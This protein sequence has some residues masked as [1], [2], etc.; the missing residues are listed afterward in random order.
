MLLLADVDPLR[1]NEAASKAIMDIKPVTKSVHVEHGHVLTNEHGDGIEHFGYADGVSQPLF[2]KEDVDKGNES[3]QENKS[4]WDPSAGLNLVLSYDGNGTGAY[5]YGSYFVFRKLEQNVKGFK[6]KEEE[7]ADALHLEGHDAERAGALL[8]GRFEDGTPITLQGA[9]GMRH[10]IPNGFTF[11]DDG[12]GLRCPFQAHIR[13]VNP[14]TE[15]KNGHRI[16]RRGIP[17]GNRQPDLGDQPTKDVGLLFMCYQQRIENQFEAMQ[18]HWANDPDFNGPGVGLDP[19]V[20]QGD[21][22]E[23]QYAFEW[24]KDEPEKGKFTFDAFVKMRGGE[25]FFAPSISFLKNL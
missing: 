18:A 9:E 2:L 7:M 4:V 21:R 20:G 25:Y 1:L 8:V 17:Y 3:G 11:Q 15:D 13:K 23:Q 14:R 12:K 22:T 16:A 10:P 5:S 6:K 24:G 19:I